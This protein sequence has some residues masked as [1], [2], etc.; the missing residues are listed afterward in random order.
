MGASA[1]GGGFGEIVRVEEE[2]DTGSSAGSEDGDFSNDSVGERQREM[3]MDM[4]MEVVG[5]M[6]LVGDH[7]RCMYRG[8]D[9]SAKGD[10]WA[11]NMSLT[12]Y[13]Q[14]KMVFS[15][16]RTMAMAG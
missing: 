11:S 9:G 8:V 16:T 3:E 5:M 13:S 15:V 1:M 12:F 6:G 4:E 2:D 10:V 7:N 14:P